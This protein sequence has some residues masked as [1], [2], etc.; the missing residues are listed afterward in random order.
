MELLTTILLCLPIVLLVTLFIGI[1]KKNKRLWIISL[2][3]F[4]IITLVDCAYFIPVYK[5]D[6][7]I[8]HETNSVE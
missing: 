1:V 8:T 3:F 6:S 5:T 7:K 2:I 4:V